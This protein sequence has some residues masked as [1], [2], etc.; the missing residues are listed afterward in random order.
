MD[1][2]NND[3]KNNLTK[4]NNNDRDDNADMDISAMRL[5]RD[6]GFS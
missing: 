4:D 3:Y 2:N 1:I 6:P 5:D